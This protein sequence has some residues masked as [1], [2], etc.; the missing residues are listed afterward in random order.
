MMKFDL[1]WIAR[2]RNRCKPGLMVKT[3]GKRGLG[4]AFNLRWK[5]YFI[6]S[7]PYRN[8]PDEDDNDKRITTLEAVP[9]KSLRHRRTI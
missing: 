9:F 6:K 8:K 5:R 1:D 7:I 4:S 3:I 2:Q